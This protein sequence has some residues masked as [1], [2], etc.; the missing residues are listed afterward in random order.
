MKYPYWG[1]FNHHKNS[2]RNPYVHVFSI[3][4]PVVKALEEKPI[5]EPLLKRSLTYK[6]N[7]YPVKCRRHFFCSMKQKSLAIPSD[8]STIVLL[9]PNAR[10]CGLLPCEG[11]ILKTLKTLMNRIQNSYDKACIIFTGVEEESNKIEKNY[12]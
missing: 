7:F 10:I 5:I 9:N 3:L 4:Y 2:L 6:N 12:R 8:S 11:G 1:E